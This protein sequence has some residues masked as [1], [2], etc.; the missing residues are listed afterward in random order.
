[1]KQTNWYKNSVIYQIYPKSFCDKNGDGIGDIKGIIS[2]LDYLQQ[3]G[4]NCVRLSPVYDSPQEDN[5]YDISNY[6]T[7]YAPY[8][9]MD[10]FKEMLD[11]MH[12]RGIRLIMD[13]VVNHT[14]NEHNWFKEAIK[15]PQS[16][17]R[18]YYII[19]KGKHHGKKAPTNWSG[20]FGGSTWERIGD[21]EDYYL[22]LFAKGQP[23]LNWENPELREEIKD[24]LRFWLDMGVDGFRCDVIT[25]ISKTQTFKS[26]FPKIALTG[27][28]NFINGPKL[29]QYLHELYTDVLSHYDCMTVGE[30]VLSNID[31]AILLVE[32]ERQELSMV[33][34]FDHTD[35]DNLMGIKYMYREF[36]LKRL[37]K[38]FNHW[39][40]GMHNV[41]WNS[42]FLEN[43]DQRRCVGR[44]GTRDDGKFRELSSKML[45]TMYFFLQGTPFIYEGQEIGMTNPHFKSIDETVDIELRNMNNM[46]KKNIF[47]RPII[48]PHMLDVTRDNAR[49][50][51]QWDDSINAGFSNVKPWLNVCSNYKSINTIE[52]IKDKNSVF[53]YYKSLIDLRI[54]N[55]VIRE[56]SYEE[57]KVGGN[58]VYVY[59]RTFKNK[60]FLIVCS[61]KDK[62]IKFKYL[63]KLSGYNLVLSNYNE[64][65]TDELYPYEA[66]VYYKEK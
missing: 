21:S 40:N 14:S 41:G 28:K 3:L 47:L 50:P 9:T 58:N 29:H 26:S 37:K 33:F 4:V 27:S 43:H 66:R 38:V 23:D 31:Q 15:N 59:K 60:E 64:H 48:W 2:K 53:Y 63:N 36:K 44:F 7:I 54:D 61:F 24:V 10:D 18:D 62:D 52:A 39:Q 35:T 22:H 55:E 57:V 56:G 17:Y 32:P 45:G 34:N 12:K 13:L 49:T 42:L 16:K 46:A 8:G 6:K 51:M 5:G 65:K 19:K 11:G 1:M 20:F 25:L 30:T